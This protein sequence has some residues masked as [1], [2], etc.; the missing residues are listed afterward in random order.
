MNIVGPFDTWIDQQTQHVLLPGEKVSYHKTGPPFPLSPPYSDT[1]QRQPSPP[2]SEFAVTVQEDLRLSSGDFWSSVGP[3]MPDGEGLPPGLCESMEL[4]ESWFNTDEPN[5]SVEPHM[6]PPGD[7]SGRSGL[8]ILKPLEANC[9]V[10]ILHALSRILSMYFSS[11]SILICTRFWTCYN[12]K[13]SQG[14]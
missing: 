14:L 13:T 9:S 2:T 1:P 5:V 4:T 12:S 7:I 8:E 6:T 3:S 10:T 11:A